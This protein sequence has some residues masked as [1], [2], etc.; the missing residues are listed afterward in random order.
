M[1]RKVP[2]LVQLISARAKSITLDRS[3]VVIVAVV[4]TT[5]PQLIVTMDYTCTKAKVTVSLQ[6]LFVLPN[7][8]QAI[9]N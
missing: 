1:L 9:V 7:K 8:Q 6:Q 5:I 4:H 2:T 3:L